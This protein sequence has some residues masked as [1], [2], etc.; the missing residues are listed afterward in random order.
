MLGEELARCHVGAVLRE[1]P[2]RYYCARCLAGLVE[3]VAWTKRDARRAIAVLFRWPIG[4]TIAMRRR[5]QPCRGCGQVGGARLG[6]VA[7]GS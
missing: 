5:R 6:A 3:T 2:G 4:L 7:G 1:R